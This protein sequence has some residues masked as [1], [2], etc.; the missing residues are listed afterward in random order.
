MSM[1][2]IS[3]LLSSIKNAA[4]ANKPAI[5]TFYSK[6]NESIAKVLEKKG[7]LEEV[8]VFKPK[9][10]AYKKLAIKLAYTDGFPKV[11][12]VKQISKPGRRIYR[13]YA[14]LHKIEAGLGVAV[15]STSRGIMDAESA[16]RKKLGGELICEVR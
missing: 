15:V 11:S 16:K 12:E 1:D 14:R 3:Q 2:R 7:F 4:M 9:E 6:Q 10:T 5:E 8:K 13:S